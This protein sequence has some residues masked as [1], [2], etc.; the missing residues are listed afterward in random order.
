MKFSTFPR[1]LLR[2]TIRLSKSEGRI[3]RRNALRELDRFLARIRKALRAEYPPIGK[4]GK[5]KTPALLPIGQRRC[6]ACR[7]YAPSVGALAR[8]FVKAHGGKCLCGWKSGGP[9]E[10]FRYAI[11]AHLKRAG[12][13]S[14]HFTLAG[15][16]KIGGA[17]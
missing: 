6:F 17:M 12:D 16:Q 10:L 1:E 8:H 11:A 7:A 15:L 13:L 2:L 5:A 9:T 3:A 4:D 14:V